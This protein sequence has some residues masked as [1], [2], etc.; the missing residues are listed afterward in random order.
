MTGWL[1][2]PVE[3]CGFGT[4]PLPAPSAFVFQPSLPHCNG[5]TPQYAIPVYSSSSF[6]VPV[7]AGGAWALPSSSFPGPIESQPSR[8]SDAMN[9]GGSLD[10]QSHLR[11]PSDVL[12]YDERLGL[13]SGSST[14]GTDSENGLVMEVFPAVYSSPESAR[15][16]GVNPV[17]TTLSRRKTT[18]VPFT[19]GVSSSRKRASKEIVDQRDNVDLS[20]TEQVHSSEAKRQPARFPCGFQGCSLGFGSKAACVQHETQHASKPLVH[21][22]CASFSM[23]CRLDVPV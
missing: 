13:D 22:L 10:S 7:V 6:P 12:L 17:A 23:L 1:P 4:L 14:T 20:F 21:T 2:N 18:R 16:A 3:G 5:S 11:H 15:R 9:S 8:F 19:D